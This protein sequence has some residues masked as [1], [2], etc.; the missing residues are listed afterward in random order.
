MGK[1]YS[2][3]EEIIIA[4]NGANNASNSSLEQKIEVYGTVVAS[5]LVLFLL[6]ATCLLCKKCKK[7]VKTWARKEF[8]T[9]IS[10]DQLDKTA[11]QQ[12][13]ANAQYA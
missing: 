7:G 6:C 5:F 8:I 10:L 11:R 4:Q 9:A 3:S 2:K 1:S 13:A 12:T